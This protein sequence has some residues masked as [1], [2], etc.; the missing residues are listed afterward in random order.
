MVSVCGGGGMYKCVC[1]CVCVCVCVTDLCVLYIEHAHM[2]LLCISGRHYQFDP[3][4]NEVKKSFSMFI[5]ITDC[6]GKPGAATHAWS[7]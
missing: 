7:Y 2:I 4:M 6:H 1:L 3:L 5:F